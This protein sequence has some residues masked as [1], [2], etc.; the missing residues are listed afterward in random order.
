MN[1]NKRRVSGYLLI[2]GMAFL[3]IG[4]TT[5]NTIFSWISVGFIVI[6]LFLGGRWMRQ[7]RRP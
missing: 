6:S 5:D 7:R 1:F 2:F 4:I 3:V